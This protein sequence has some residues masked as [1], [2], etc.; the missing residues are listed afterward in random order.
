M[1]PRSSRLPACLPSLQTRCVPAA[2][3]QAR[4][5]LGVVDHLF[6][7][8]GWAPGSTPAHTHPRAFRRLYPWALF[9]PGTYHPGDDV[10]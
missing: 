10:T 2:P 4:S 6:L 8:H 7:L 9:A 3:A 5:R 1:S